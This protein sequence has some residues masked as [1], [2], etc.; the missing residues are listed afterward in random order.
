MTGPYFL[1]KGERGLLVGKTGSGKSQQGYFHL[2]NAA[3]W[4]VIIF[5]TKIEDEFFSV[6]ESDESLEL[7]EGVET[8]ENYAKGTRKADMSD[9]ILVRPTE[10]EFQDPEAMDEY[11]RIAFHRF[12]ACFLYFDEVGNFNKNGRALPNLMN[13]LCRGRA[14]GKTTLMG[15]QRPSGISRSILTETDNFYIHQLTDGRDRKTLAEVVPEFDKF[16]KP[17]EFHFWHFTHKH[18][19]EPELF[20]PVPQLIIKPRKIYK[21]KWI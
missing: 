12:G 2:Q 9:F 11:C 17:P 3:C 4:P 8:F 19:E 1:K 13:I 21:R 18:H 14:K 20:A 10:T 15:S 6:P 5:D 16:P 7:I